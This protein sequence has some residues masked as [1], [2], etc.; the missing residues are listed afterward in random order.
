MLNAPSPP[1]SHSPLVAANRHS[2]DGVA[3]VH[4]KNGERGVATFV[5]KISTP[6]WFSASSLLLWLWLLLAFAR[7]RLPLLP[8]ISY[9]TCLLPLCVVIAPFFLAFISSTSVKGLEI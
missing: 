3:R 1:S 4:V 5:L 2:L 6:L 7:P 8:L 9:T